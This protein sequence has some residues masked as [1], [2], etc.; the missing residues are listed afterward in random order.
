MLGLI[1][2]VRPENPSED[3]RFFKAASISETP[4]SGSP[5]SAGVNS[6]R[7]YYQWR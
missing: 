6:E 2:Y 3:T 7:C 4:D 1:Y 5:L